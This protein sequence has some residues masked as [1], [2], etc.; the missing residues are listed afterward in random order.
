MKF[1]SDNGQIDGEKLLLSEQKNGLTVEENIMILFL[2]FVVVRLVSFMVLR[3]KY[4]TPALDS[5][6]V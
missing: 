6:T 1:D 5:N 3:R 4:K 2:H